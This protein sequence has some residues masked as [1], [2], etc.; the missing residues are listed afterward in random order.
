M[1]SAAQGISTYRASIIRD[2]IREFKDEAYFRGKDASPE[3]IVMALCEGLLDI[4]TDPDRSKD[5]EVAREYAER[6][7]GITSTKSKKTD[8][9]IDFL[10]RFEAI[11][12]RHFPNDID[13]DIDVFFEMCRERLK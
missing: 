6:L 8:N 5:I 2:A 12:G 3:G 11:V 7:R 13:R 9:A 1:I 10:D 4:L